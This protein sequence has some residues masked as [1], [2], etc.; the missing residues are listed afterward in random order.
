MRTRLKVLVGCE[1]S[2]IVRRAFAARGH[3]AYSVDLKPSEDDSDHHYVGDVRDYLH[4]E[5]DVAIFHTPC[6]RLANSGAQWLDRPPKKLTSNYS[7]AERAAYENM[8]LAE[9]KAF[10]RESLK[11]G[12]QLFS[13]CWNAPIPRIAMENPIMHGEAKKLIVG[14]R[15]HTQVIQPWQF[16]TEIAGPDNIKKSTCLWLK[17]LTRLLHTGDLDGKTAR[18]EIHN[19]PSGENRPAHR[20]RFF[21][22]IAAAMAQQWGDE[23]LGRAA[24]SA[25]VP[26]LR[27]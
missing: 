11:A 20:S 9:R 16:G 15:P 22:G 1:C 24:R 4:K 18:P 8:N 2:G 26:W 17:G 12:A 10:M 19:T 5:W 3:D 27:M 25:G 13:D 23:A 7:L 14:F 6:T 21:P